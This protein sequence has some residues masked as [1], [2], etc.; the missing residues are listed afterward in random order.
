MLL[1]RRSLFLLLASLF[2]FSL[3]ILSHHRARASWGHI[4]QVVGLGEH[5][6]DLEDHESGVETLS[7]QRAQRL[8]SS[9]NKSL[10]G[11][12]TPKAIGLNYTRAI[13]IARTKDEDVSWLDRELGDIL[14]PNGPFEK[15]IYA[16][17]D[18]SAP[19]H[20]PSNK[21]HEGMAYL[22]YII[23]RYD[24]LP[25]VSMFLHAHQIAWHNNHILNRDAAHMIRYLSPE[26]VTREG[27]MNLRCHWDPGC[28]S[29]IHPGAIEVD[30]RKDEE[31]LFAEY[32][33]QLFPL[34]EIPQ[35]VAQ[36]CCA[37]FALSRARI[38]AIPLQRYIYLR[39]WLQRTSLDDYMSGRLLEYS[40][41]FLFTGDSVVCPEMHI[42]SCDGYGICFGGA[43]ELNRWFELRYFTKAYKNELQEWKEKQDL[44][45]QARKIGAIDDMAELE[46]PNLGRDV[47]LK[48]KIKTMSQ[49][50][51]AMRDEAF[52]RG[53]D[54]HVRALE[55]GRPWLKGDGF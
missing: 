46:I 35:V 28:P 10:F 9:A 29:W 7:D 1:R 19:L 6:P 36:P 49:Q 26:H 50:L 18:T 37:Q 41:H 40:W 24:S 53:R 34:D 25:D 3:F 42:C 54:P 5:F 48:E 55:A 2:T 15:A 21:G 32:W 38:R 30:H 8:S 31:T 45:E 11:P 22:T 39:N 47:F 33:H 44:I 16:T 27:Y 43:T 51:L 52:L 20:T 4:P 23:D 17:D 14:A 12:G 13:V